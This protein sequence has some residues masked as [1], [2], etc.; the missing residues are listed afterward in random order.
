MCV[1]VPAVSL[2]ILSKKIPAVTARFI[3]VCGA[4]LLASV[5]FG[6]GAYQRAKDGKTIVWNNSPKPG[7][8][9]AWSGGRDSD[10]YATGFG[11]LT[12]YTPRQQIGT[13]SD[14]PTAAKPIVYGRYF[15]HMVRGK[16]DGPVN[17]HSKGKTSHAIFVDGRLT[18]GWAAGPAPSR[19]VGQQRAPRAKQEA[20]AGP[21]SAK[22][23]GV[24][25]PE[26]PAER[27]PTAARRTAKA[28]V[29]KR[30][31]AARR[32]AETESPP[33]VEP[34]PIVNRSPNDTDSKAS[35]KEEPKGKIDDAL[36]SL[37]G[38]PSSLRT[39]PGTDASPAGAKQEAAPSPGVN[40]RLTRQ[41]V[42]DLADAEARRHG[43]DPAD[44]QRPEPQYNAADN[45]W[46]LFY[47]QKPFDEMVEMGKHFSVMVDDKTKSTV[48]VAGR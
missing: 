18:S 36:R 11:T 23:S 10:G 19:R 22:V 15:G 24:A 9:A 39:N 40:A 35:T 31:E 38:P 12:W 48:F 45:T 25:G 33:T 46:S 16:F 42:I 47:D 7:D 2:A 5:A 28:A 14:K 3:F 34:S 41:E 27:P 44:Y 29:Q 8:T 20:A 17:L 37:V 26:P 21:A 6:D 32:E 43:Y 30:D 1:N 4:L 13:E